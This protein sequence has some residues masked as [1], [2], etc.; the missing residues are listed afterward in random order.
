MN[1]I[2]DLD[3]VQ[4]RSPPLEDQHL[5]NLGGPTFKRKSEMNNC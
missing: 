5:N 4:E 2:Q 1:E 3:G